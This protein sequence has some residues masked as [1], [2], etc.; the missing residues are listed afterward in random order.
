MRTPGGLLSDNEDITLATE[1]SEETAAL[2]IAKAV[3]TRHSLARR[4]VLKLRRRHPD[5]TPAEI[6]RILERHYATSIT[7]AG[8]VISASVIA[9]NVGIALIPGVGAAAAGA[10]AAGT[11]AAKKTGKEV[12]KATAKSVAKQAAKNVALGTAKTGAQRVAGLLPAGD[13]QL[14]FEITAIFGLALADIHAMNLD[15][16][17]SQALIYGLTNEKVS[18]KQIATMATDLAKASSDQSPEVVVAGQTDWSHWANTLADT[19]PAGAAQGLVRTIQTGHLDPVRENLSGR[20]LAAIDYGVGALTGGVARFV[21]G[22]DVVE[23][24]RT[25]F[26]EPPEEFPAH[27]AIVTTSIEGDEDVESNRAL[28]ALEDAGKAAGGWVAG[29]ATSVGTGVASGAVAMG[30]GVA[31]VTGTVTRKFR[32]VDIDGDG[33]P[34]EPQALTAV[35]G[36]GGAL[37]GAAGAAGGGVVGIFKSKKKKGDETRDK[38]LDHD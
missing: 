36:V 34:D 26:S 33:V 8:A 19:L 20:Q 27:L 37:A 35:K 25:A 21:F 5:A 13:Q 12:A 4:Y 18:Q 10:R 16:D 38:A 32:S 15:K 23:S 14:Q 1:L 3:S 2:D 7:T 17:Q 24:A 29:T 6:I 31:S 28:A 9:A 11:E 22:R 30:S